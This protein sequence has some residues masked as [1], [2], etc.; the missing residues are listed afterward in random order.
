MANRSRLLN[1]QEIRAC[2]VGEVEPLAG[3]IVIVDYDPKWRESAA[4]ED[5]GTSSRARW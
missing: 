1:E 5:P 3:K 2:T 4:V